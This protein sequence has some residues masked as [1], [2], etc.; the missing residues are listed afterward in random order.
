MIAQINALYRIATALES[1]DP[2]ASYEL[3]SNLRKMI[4]GEVRFLLE[5]TPM[6]KKLSH[7]NDQLEISK[8]AD[9]WHTTHTNVDG[10]WTRETTG[11][12]LTPA[13]VLKVIKNEVVPGPATDEA[14]AVLEQ[15]I[16]S[17]NAVG[18][19]RGD[20]MGGGSVSLPEASQAESGG[21]MDPDEGTWSA[22]RYMNPE[23]IWDVASVNTVKRAIAAAKFNPALRAKLAPMFKKILSAKR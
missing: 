3:S 15:D 23:S 6:S 13:D 14:V 11:W 2:L 16:S 4:A 1:I 17:G 9:G 5:L 20:E 22:Q 18:I 7:P 10:N 12:R 8:S 21:I 19:P